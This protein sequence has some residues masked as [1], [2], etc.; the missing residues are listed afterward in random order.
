MLSVMLTDHLCGGHWPLMC[1]VTIVQG[2]FRIGIF[3]SSS[4]RTVS[5]GDR[6]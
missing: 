5:T 3:S 2:R 4:D 6:M 1:T